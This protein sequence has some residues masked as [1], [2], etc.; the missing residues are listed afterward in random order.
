MLHQQKQQFLLEKLEY[1]KTKTMSDKVDDEAMKQIITLAMNNDPAFLVKFQET[2]QVFIQKLMERA[3]NLVTT[4]L[5][6]CAHLRLGFYTKEIARYTK[7][8]VRAVEGKK[9]RIRKKLDIPAT[10]DLNVWMM[11]V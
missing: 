9:Y 1:L 4:D 11:Q 2:H 6:M 7:L 3:P 10:E 8:S 5:A